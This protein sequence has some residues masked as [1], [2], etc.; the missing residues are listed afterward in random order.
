MKRID[1]FDKNFDRFCH[2]ICTAC[3][4][5]LTEQVLSRYGNS[6]SRMQLYTS[7]LEPEKPYPFMKGKTAYYPLTIIFKNGTWETM[8]IQWDTSNIPEKYIHFSPFVFGGDGIE[9]KICESVD[10]AFQ[11]QIEGK[12]L[13][14]IQ[15]KN[16]PVVAIRMVNNITPAK[17]QKISVWF[18]QE[19]TNQVNGVI[20][21]HTGQRLDNHWDIAICAEDEIVRY[22]GKNY[23]KAF[24]VSF[25]ACM[26]DVCI[27]WEEDINL[28]DYME[29]GDITFDLSETAPHFQPTDFE[30]LRKFIETRGVDLV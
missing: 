17:I 2:D 7:F 11:K 21:K 3:K 5:Q 10:P 8:W 27:T 23:M 13:C 22:K 25:T 18:Q 28:S 26:M 6:V 19:L 29:E 9:L 16:T 1:V 4:E 14:H 15:D 24:L 20:E 30:R 12:K